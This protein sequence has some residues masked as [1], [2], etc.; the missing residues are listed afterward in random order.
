MTTEHVGNSLIG[1]PIRRVEDP[2]L[3]S[4][5]GCYVDDIEIPGMLHMVVLRSHYPH[6]KILSIN[7]DAAKAMPGVVT[8][9]TGQ[10]VQLS[11]PAAPMV[12]GQKSRRIP[13]SPA[14]RCT[15][16]GFPWPPSWLKAERSL[17][18]LRMRSKSNTRHYRR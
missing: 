11:I 7:T 6:A 15:R 16:Q 4:G 2:I 9:V 13:S 1:A 3:V 10:D 18:M 12:V 14:M 17:K 8:V 5:K